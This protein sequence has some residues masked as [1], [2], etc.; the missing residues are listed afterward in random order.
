MAIHLQR[1]T[2]LIF[3]FCFTMVIVNIIDNKYFEN[4]EAA[5][6]S[7]IIRN[8]DIVD[9]FSLVKPKFTFVT[10]HPD[11]NEIDKEVIFHLQLV[12]NDEVIN[13]NDS[14]YLHI[15]IT[16]IIYIAVHII[17]ALTALSSGIFLQFKKRPNFDRDN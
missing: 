16:D 13:D 7:K 9:G 10:I 12:E 14:H 3:I 4:N 1:I 15:N 8:V 17:L 2:K 5:N 11:R 6:E